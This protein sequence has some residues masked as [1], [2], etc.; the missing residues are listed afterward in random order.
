MVTDGYGHDP[1][2]PEPVDT[3]RPITM[4]G[5]HTLRHVDRFVRSLGLE[6]V[7]NAERGWYDDDLGDDYPDEF[8]PLVRRSFRHV[9]SAGR[10]RQ[11]LRDEPSAVPLLT[12][13]GTSCVGWQASWSGVRLARRLAPGRLFVLATHMWMMRPGTVPH[14]GVYVC[15]WQPPFPT[16]ALVAW[17]PRARVTPGPVPLDDS[18]RAPAAWLFESGEG[19]FGWGRRSHR[20]AWLRANGFGH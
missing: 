11:V 7:L 15:A 5:L 14:A 9:G 12:M 16:H 3:G 6:V 19:E 4:G 13:H 17:G 10:L 1:D 8:D 18:L 2:L 20:D